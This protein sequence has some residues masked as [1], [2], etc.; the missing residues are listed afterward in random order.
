MSGDGDSGST[1][2]CTCICTQWCKRCGYS[3][4]GENGSDD[5]QPLSAPVR[6]RTRFLLLIICSVMCDYIFLRLLLISEH[7]VCDKVC[8][9]PTSSQTVKLDATHAGPDAVILK[10]GRR[11]CGAG[12]ALGSHAISQDKV[13]HRTCSKL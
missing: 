4:C 6:S 1:A 7:C 2:W 3:Q 9:Q 5:S 10:G 11:I 12:A 13:S 8:A